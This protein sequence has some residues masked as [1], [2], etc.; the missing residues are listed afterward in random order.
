M[1]C[2]QANRAGCE[3]KLWQKDLLPPQ[4]TWITVCEISVT[5]ISLPAFVVS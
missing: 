1:V 3:A 4:L 2:F 5:R